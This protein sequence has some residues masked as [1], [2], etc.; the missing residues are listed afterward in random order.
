M[1][2]LFGKKDRRTRQQIETEHG[3]LVALY[4][5][6]PPEKKKGAGHILK[7]IADLEKELK[8]EA[9]KGPRGSMRVPFVVSIVVGGVA[10][11]A[12]G[13]LAMKFLAG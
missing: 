11:F 7:R 6:L 8:G 9:P 2:G 3:H 10:A 12:I 5:K 1:F 13:F 4:G